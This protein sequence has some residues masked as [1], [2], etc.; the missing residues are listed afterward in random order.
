MKVLLTGANGF[1]GSHILDALLDRG[2]R[3]VV[4]LRPAAR[5][6]WLHDKLDRIEIQSGTL[7]DPAV[8]E[9]ALGGVTHVIHCA[10]CTK[11]VNPDG[12]FEVNR[13]ATRQ[14]V[15]AI[16]RHTPNLDRLIYVSSLAASRPATS[17]APATEETVSAPVTIYGRSKLA[18]E[19]EIREHCRVPF[20]ILRPAAVYG[21]RDTDFLNLFRAVASGVVPLLQKGR[22][23]L[24]LVHVGDLAELVAICLDHPR[25]VNGIYHVAEEQVVTSREL[26][27]EIARQMGL[28]PW[29]P[30]LP[31]V[32]LWLIC[33]G[34][35][36]ISKA[37]GRPHILSRHK[38][39][40]MVAP[41]WVSGTDRLR[42]EL[43]Y[44]CP[45]DLSQGISRTLAWYRG[46]GWLRQKPMMT[47]RPESAGPGRLD[48]RCE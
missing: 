6:Q 20:G 35:D 18:G 12:Y 33:A 45:T 38:Y 26:V 41:G 32:L 11:A 47:G 37:T 14:L 15:D 29:T 19:R 25:A 42:R 9:V 22:Q 23:Q 10:G 7:N 34:R 44:A 30:P 21:P 24:S 8:L 16:N 46:Q 48:R 17:D 36:L 1:V 28:R 4:L 5:R 13:D 27:D 40:E 3:P 39:A 31:R 2:F 43:G